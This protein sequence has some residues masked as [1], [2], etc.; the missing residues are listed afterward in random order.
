MLQ[1]WKTIL[2]NILIYIREDHFRKKLVNPPLPQTEKGYA[3]P[4]K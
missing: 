4:P 2:K 1:N 3:P